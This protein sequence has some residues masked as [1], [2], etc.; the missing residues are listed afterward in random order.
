MDRFYRAVYSQLLTRSADAAC[1]RTKHGCMMDWKIN[2]LVWNEY[3]VE[4]EVPAAAAVYPRGIHGEL[5]RALEE[6]DE[7]SAGSATLD[8]AEFG[9]ADD[10][11]KSTDVLLLWSHHAHHEVPDDRVSAVVQRVREGMGLVVLHSAHFHK[12][13][14]RLMGTSCRLGGW[15]VDGRRERVWTIRPAHPIAQ[16]LD[17]SF[18]IPETEMYCEPFDVPEPD[19]VVFISSFEGGEVFRSGCLW[20]RGRGWVF[21][22]RPGHET[23]PVYRQEPVRRVL[24]NAVRWLG[25]QH[26]EGRWDEEAGP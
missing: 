24:A 17:A 25:Q 21:Y 5:V 26:G 4:R 3:R 20:R 2:A 16:G 18:E 6:T 13:F 22:F 9:L 23:Y 7:I 1:P 11:L 12:V 19:E 8:D 14:L 15:R 10:R